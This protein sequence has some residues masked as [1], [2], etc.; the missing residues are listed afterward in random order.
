[1]RP[2]RRPHP[3]ASVLTFAGDVAV[4]WSDRQDM[5]AWGGRLQTTFAFTEALFQ[6]RLTHAASRARKMQIFAASGM[7]WRTGARGNSGSG[8]RRGGDHRLQF[9]HHAVAGPCQ[10]LADQVPA[11]DQLAH[12]SRLILNSRPDNVLIR[13]CASGALLAREVAKRATR[14]AHGNRIDKIGLYRVF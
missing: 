14:T 1:M 11:P 8:K 6:P 12:V 3:A 10:I 2:G 7:E 5:R 9:G 13:I 4:K